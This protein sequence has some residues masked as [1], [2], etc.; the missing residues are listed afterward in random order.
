MIMRA[1]ARFEGEWKF[2]ELPKWDYDPAGGDGWP[3][4]PKREDW[5]MLDGKLVLVDYAASTI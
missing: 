2:E 3:G 5:G 4:E 1:A